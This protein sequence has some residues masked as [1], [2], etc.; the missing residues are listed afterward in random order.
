MAGW[1]RVLSRV[2][3]AFFGGIFFAFSGLSGSEWVV[4]HMLSAERP[5]LFSFCSM[6]HAVFSGLSR[7]GWLI[8][9]MLRLRCVAGVEWGPN[10]AVVG[11][12]ALCQQWEQRR[13]PKTSHRDI[14]PPACKR[15]Q[16][17]LHCF[18]SSSHRSPYRITAA[19]LDDTQ[20][21]Q[22]KALK[23][24]WLHECHPPFAPVSTRAQPEIG[25]LAVV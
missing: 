16:H 20:A 13:S 6:G 24:H 14:S 18:L 19:L 4:L 9:L 1:V 25:E 12:T 23:T 22:Q 2:G 11:P 21:R 5:S 10:L 7:R 17:T 8:G 3:D 15:Q